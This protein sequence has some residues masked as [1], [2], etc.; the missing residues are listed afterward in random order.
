MNR[1][2]WFNDLETKAEMNSCAIG[3]IGEIMGERYMASYAKVIK[4]AITLKAL[5]E[6]W[7]V[8]KAPAETEANMETTHTDCIVNVTKVQS[9]LEPWYVERILREKE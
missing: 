2:N 6:A 4:I 3:I 9:F 8:K 7:D 5:E 1:T